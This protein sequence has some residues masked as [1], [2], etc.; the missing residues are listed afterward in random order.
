MALSKLFIP[1]TKNNLQ[2][3]NLFTWREKILYIFFLEKEK[4]KAYVF[5]RS[6][7]WTLSAKIPELFV[8][9]II[10][11]TIFYPLLRLIKKSFTY[12]LFQSI[13]AR[14]MENYCNEIV[15]IISLKFRFI[16]TVSI[17][18][19]RAQLAI[20]ACAYLQWERS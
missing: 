19:V 12:Y 16:E 14:H 15:S 9:I 7:V 20:C 10:F 1:T 3:W 8:T 13:I 6:Y 17:E 2:R 18:A 5:T 11:R 4:R